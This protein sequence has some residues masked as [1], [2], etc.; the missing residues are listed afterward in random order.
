MWNWLEPGNSES[1]LESLDHA[2][3]LLL[4]PNDVQ[5]LE[6]KLLLLNL[7]AQYANE[8]TPWS[9]ELLARKALSLP[10]DVVEPLLQ[11]LIDTLQPKLLTASPKTTKERNPRAARN[12]GLRPILGHS[13]ATSE[14]EN[15]RQI[16]KDSELLYTLGSVYFWLQFDSSPASM[17]VMA[18]F[19]L[20]VIDDLDPAYRTQGCYLIQKLLSSGS[21]AVLQSLGLFKLFKEE[22]RTCFNLL[23]RLTPGTVSLRL[24]RAAYPTMVQLINFEE[25]LVQSTNNKESQLEGKKQERKY[26]PYLELLDTHVLG[27]VSHIMGHAEGPSNSV[28]EYLLRFSTELVTDYIGA[29]IL[30]CYSRLSS[31]LCRIITDPFLIDTE[32]GP[33][34]VEASLNFQRVTLL[35]VIQRQG[36]S[37]ELLFNYRYDLLA[38]WTVFIKRVVKYRVGT[39]KSHDLVRT[40]VGL[41][42]TL[43]AFDEEHKIKLRADIEQI[44]KVSPETSDYFS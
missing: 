37:C 35:V 18:A 32:N 15:K 1:K 27:L 10:K 33:Q 8:N 4:I 2:I 12:G 24:M 19:A 5:D 11:N 3:S 13:V 23:P 42:N 21:H 9:N 29:A 44:T 16:W 30:A 38:A 14:E 39:R 17:G 6:T 28:L 41:M 34:V 40:N 20:N 31:I 7:I 43:A 36:G 26:L 25:S 22:V